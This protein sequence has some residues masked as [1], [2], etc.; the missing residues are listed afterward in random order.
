[1]RFIGRSRKFGAFSAVALAFTFGMLI[2]VKLRVVESVPRQAYAEPKRAASERT[3]AGFKQ[4]KAPASA[5]A[6]VQDAA[7]NQHATA[8]EQSPQVEGP[9]APAASGD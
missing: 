8:P 5:L 9:Q 1:M 2:W 6:P 4:G 7:A 3:P